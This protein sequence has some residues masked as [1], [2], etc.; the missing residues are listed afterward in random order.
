MNMASIWKLPV[1]FVV[2]HN[3]FA[4]TTPA[5]YSC[6]VD[7]ISKRAQGYGMPG[8]T[9]DGNDVLAVREAAGEAVARARS[10]EGPFLL[11]N[12]TY[13]VRGHFE[14]DP[15]KYREQSDVEKQVESNDPIDRFTAVL[16]KK[17]ILGKR[18]AKQIWDEVAQEIADAVQFA[19]DSPLPEPEEALD[20]LYASPF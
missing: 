1:I 12:K 3:Q 4:S 15:Q 13:R 19:E 8:L 6:S 5:T 20:D 2:E 16:G 9:V 17:R 7:E 11:E 18:A 10:G 14:G